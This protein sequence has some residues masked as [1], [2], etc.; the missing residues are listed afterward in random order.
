MKHPDCKWCG[1][2]LF[3]NR[4]HTCPEIFIH[5]IREGGIYGDEIIVRMNELDIKWKGKK[6]ILSNKKETDLKY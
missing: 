2:K 4:E 1:E 3:K 6:L 5:L